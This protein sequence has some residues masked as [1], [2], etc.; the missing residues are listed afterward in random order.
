MTAR[1]SFM[2][3]LLLL[4]C[5]GCSA[6]P[7]VVQET[8]AARAHLIKLVAAYT[9]ANEH[10][11]RGPRNLD[12]LRP[13]L[14][15][16]DATDAVLRSPNDQ[17]PFVIHWGVDVLSDSAAAAPLVLAYEKRGKDG[18]R[19]VATTLRTTHVMTEAEFRQAGFPKGH[20]PPS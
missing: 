6:K 5:A 8:D 18:K 13:H 16:V 1:T 17:E 2:L 14:K 7:V 11:R 15:N 3:V 10:L 19:Y 20:K 9:Q 4:G 12:E